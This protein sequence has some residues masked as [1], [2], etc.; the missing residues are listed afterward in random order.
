MRV[1]LA[2]RHRRRRRVPVSA[3]PLN[4]LSYSSGRILGSNLRCVNLNLSHPFVERH[5][6]IDIDR[7]FPGAIER[8]VQRGRH[9]VV[10]VEPCFGARA[11]AGRFDLEQFLR[12][13][14]DRIADLRVVDSVLTVVGDDGAALG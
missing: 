5:D 11:I 2:P 4:H 12:H 3:A 6:R 1:R 10:L 8:R 9:L 13:S 14:R 7:N